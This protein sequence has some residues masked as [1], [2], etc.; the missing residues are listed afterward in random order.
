MRI[1]MAIG[2]R[3]RVVYYLYIRIF[4]HSVTNSATV[5]NHSLWMEVPISG[6][7][8][9]KQFRKF[10]PR[11]FKIAYK[12]IVHVHVSNFHSYRT[13]VTNFKTTSCFPLYLTHTFV[14]YASP[15]SGINLFHQASLTH[16]RSCSR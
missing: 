10:D 5:V 8:D 13:L 3:I 6:K 4:Q 7:I 2:I 14:Y 16:Y 15:R 1:K 9:K 12:Y 11:L